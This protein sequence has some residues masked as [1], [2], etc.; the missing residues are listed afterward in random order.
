MSNDAIQV[1]LSTRLLT[2]SPALPFAWPNSA[3]TPVIGTPF[4]RVGFL[5]AQTA[6]PTMGA[7]AL[8]MKRYNGLMQVSLFY[9]VNT[10][11]GDP[12]RKADAVIALFP[13]GLTLTH[14]GVVVHI[15][16]TPSAAPGFSQDAWYVLP[17]SVYYRADII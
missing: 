8:D 9:P 7:G 6:N 12:R 5:A 11:E 15:D 3:Y 1:A 17:V 16:Y 2:L 13:R 4:A 14:S 10:G